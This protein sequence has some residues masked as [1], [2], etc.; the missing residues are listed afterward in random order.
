MIEFVVRNL[1]TKPILI[2]L[3]RSTF[4]SPKASRSAAFLIYRRGA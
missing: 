2:E 4:L 3:F 1:K